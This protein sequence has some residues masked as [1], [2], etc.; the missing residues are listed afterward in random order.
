MLAML[1]LENLLDPEEVAIPARVEELAAARER[2]RQDGDYVE[3][4]AVRDQL[5]ELGWE[6]RDGAQGPELRPLQ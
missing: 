2:A 1:G 4:D 6:V 3:A 5:R